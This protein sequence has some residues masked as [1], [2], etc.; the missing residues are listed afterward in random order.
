MNRRERSEHGL[1]LTPIKGRTEKP[2]STANGSDR[3]VLSLVL[4]RNGFAES[5]FMLANWPN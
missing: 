5:E 2:L 3:I 4:L 1:H